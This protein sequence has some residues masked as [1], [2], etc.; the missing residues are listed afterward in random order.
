M[1][2]PMVGA[3]KKPGPPPTGART[4]SGRRRSSRCRERARD[5]PDEERRR[6]AGAEGH[7][8]PAGVASLAE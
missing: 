6:G 5:D 7:E 2:W 8:R 1:D 4:R 3:L